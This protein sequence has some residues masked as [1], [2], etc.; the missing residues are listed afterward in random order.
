MMT[1]PRAIGRLGLILLACTV[2][3][4]SSGCS[5]VRLGMT[6]PL[7]PGRPVDLD[8]TRKIW[9]KI[10]AGTADDSDLESFTKNNRLALNQILVDQ[11]WNS[12][13]SPEI[14]TLDGFEDVL[15]RIAERIE[16]T[17]KRHPLQLE[18]EHAG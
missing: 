6:R 10:K 15:E 7:L 5:T 17:T 1:A 2:S 14:K 9:S 13:S 11:S 12:H 3:F 16:H 8:E 4:G 18:Y